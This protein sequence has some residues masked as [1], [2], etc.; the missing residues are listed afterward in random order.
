[1]LTKKPIRFS[2]S[3]RPRLAAGVPIDHIL[4]PGQPCQQRRPG[5]QQGHEQGRAVALA[6]RLQT[7]CQL[8]IQHQ[9]RK[10][11]GIVLL[12]RAWMVGGQFQQRRSSASAVF[13]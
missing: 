5:R 6:Q 10:G 12:R 9:F 1:M 11:A 13:Q 4:L 8:L 3:A 7:R 2:I